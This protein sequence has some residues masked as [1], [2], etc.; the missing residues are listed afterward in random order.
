M[1]PE[2]FNHPKIIIS[3]F[4]S[5]SQ[6][7]FSFQFGYVTFSFKSNNVDLALDQNQSDTLLERNVKNV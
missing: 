5:E 2:T 3:L 7:K 4:K 1:S 6:P